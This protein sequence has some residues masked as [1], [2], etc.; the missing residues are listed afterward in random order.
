MIANSSVY[1][2]SVAG[3]KSEVQSTY[4]NR[5]LCIRNGITSSD[6]DIRNSFPAYQKASMAILSKALNGYL[7][8]DNISKDVHI[9][10]DI[11]MEVWHNDDNISFLINLEDTEKK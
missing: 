8:K 5:D 7:T 11:G 10:Y 4:F 6:T 3:L 1:T 9:Y 2:L